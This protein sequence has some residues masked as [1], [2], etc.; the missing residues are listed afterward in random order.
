MLKSKSWI[1]GFC[2]IFCIFLLRPLFWGEDGRRKAGG[3]KEGAAKREDWMAADSIS[4]PACFREVLRYGGGT[5][6]EADAIGRWTR[7][8]EDDERRD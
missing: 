4:G 1:N 5:R 8:A 3:G 7:L 2:A 6:T